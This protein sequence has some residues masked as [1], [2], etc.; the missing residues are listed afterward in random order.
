M[1]VVQIVMLVAL[2]I[3]LVFVM[4]KAQITPVLY[5]P[6]DDFA[7]VMVLLV[8]VVSVESF[9]FRIMEIRFARSSS[10]KHLMAKNSIRTAA[11][12][13]IVAAV[14]AVV[15]VAPPILTAIQDSTSK[16][17]VLSA[18]EH[19]TFW[20]RD[21]LAFQKMVEVEVSAAS[22]VEVYLVEGD[23]FDQYEGA[24]NQSYLLRINRDN[25]VVDGEITIEVPETDHKRYVLVLYDFGSEG[26]VATVK[27]VRDISDMFTGIIPILTIAII[28][29]N[30]GWVIYLIPIAR[31]YSRGSIYK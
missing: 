7:A 10:A 28:G 9:F 5:L 15:L 26:A 19:V 23:A 22:S 1:Y 11:M 29:A 2:A 20:S 30:V 21:P 27:I 14:V 18:S 3:L 13:A 31:K 17:S 24:I 6:L 8:L 4:G 25:Y 16:V 12:V